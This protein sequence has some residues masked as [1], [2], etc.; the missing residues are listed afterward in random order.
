MILSNTQMQSANQYIDTNT[1]AT[2]NAYITFIIYVLF[3]SVLAVSQVTFPFDLPFVGLV[4]MVQLLICIFHT[5]SVGKSGYTTSIFL[6]LFSLVIL[7]LYEFKKVICKSANLEFMIHL[8][9]I[10][11]IFISYYYIVYYKKIDKITMKNENPALSNIKLAITHD[12]A[13]KPD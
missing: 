13:K 6:N 8:G 12:E 2:I 1:V 10:I 9:T 11:S 3:F 7:N 4:T 5:V